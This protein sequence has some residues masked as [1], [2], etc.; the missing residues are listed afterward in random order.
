MAFL[1][2][3]ALPLLLT[4]VELLK[5]AVET[6]ADQLLAGAQVRE[7]PGQNPELLELELAKLESWGQGFWDA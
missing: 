7:R 2:A 6:S 1:T 5:A 4:A 3:L